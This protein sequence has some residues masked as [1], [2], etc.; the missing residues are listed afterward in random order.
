[1][2]SVFGLI[3][4]KLVRA[5]RCAGSVSAISENQAFFRR[6]WT[7]VKSLAEVQPATVWAIRL[8]VVSCFLHRSRLSRQA[9][10]AADPCLPSRV[11]FCRS[12][13]PHW[14]FKRTPVPSRVFNVGEVLTARI[15][16]PCSI[17]GLF[18]VVVTPHSQAARMVYQHAYR[19]V[20]KWTSGIM[21]KQTGHRIA[22]PSIIIARSAR[23]QPQGVLCT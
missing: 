16:T 11:L 19:R 9:D 7:I 23:I 21:S 1:M 4:R 14:D 17:G 3:C 6:V 22:L 12:A 2:K 15:F 20:A 10:L 13:V 5:C 8:R 18:M